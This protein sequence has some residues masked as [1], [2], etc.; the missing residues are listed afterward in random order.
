ML[1]SESQYGDLPID[2]SSRRGKRFVDQALELDPEL[3]EGWAALG[4]YEGRDGNGDPDAAIDALAKALEMNPNNIDASNWLYSALLTTGNAAGARDIIEELVERDPLYRPA[5]S[6]AISSFVAFN[7]IDKAERLIERIAAFDPKNPDVLHARSVLLVA[8]GSAGAAA[9][10]MVQRA[11]MGNMSGPAY[12]IWS[13]AL[14]NLGAPELA[15]EK[16]P[17]FMHEWALYELG[18]VEEALQSSRSSADMGFPQTYFYILLREGRE[19]DLVDF[20]EERWPNV[21]AFAAEHAPG[22]Y[23]WGPMTDLG[24]AYKRLGNTE[25]VNE[26]T[27]MLQKWQDDMSSIGVDNAPFILSR[28]GM[29]ALMGD[30]EQAIDAM[31]QAIDGGIFMPAPSAIAFPALEFIDDPA[32]SELDQRML[33]M[34]NEQREIAGLLPFDENYQPI[35]AE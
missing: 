8:T 33:V 31:E 32:L 15:V 7:Q 2:E 25:V 18:Q 1:L 12:F 20:V 6:N 16:L 5:F 34:L 26:V 27:A 3:A 22:T 24:T 21:R 19:Q 35:P 28:A 23:D 29:Y 17:L 4:L 11:E 9:N 13:V 30:D 14:S 10:L